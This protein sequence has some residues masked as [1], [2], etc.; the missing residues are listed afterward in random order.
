MAWSENR[1]ARHILSGTRSPSSATR[2]ATRERH[3]NSNPQ[4]SPTQP[5]RQST[6][7]PTDVAAAP[8]IT[9]VT[10]AT[11]NS[12]ASSPICSPRPRSD[13]QSTRQRRRAQPLRAPPSR[14][15]TS[16]AASHPATHRERARSGG[17]S[18]RRTESP[19]SCN[20]RGQYRFLSRRAEA[21]AITITRVRR[22]RET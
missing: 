21:G 4:V 13:P 9:G 8:S 6:Q 14:Q 18:P 7:L 10:A 2:R 16:L 1:P 5:A 22:W 19:R 11:A 3:P 17:T 15:Q 12:N 20:R